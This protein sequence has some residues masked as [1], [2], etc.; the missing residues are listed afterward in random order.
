MK[1]FTIRQ[2]L[3]GM[4][5]VLAVIITALSLFFLNRFAAV[6][7]TYNNIPQIHVPQQQVV[8]ELENALITEQ[9]YIKQIH[10]VP[11]DIKSFESLSALSDESHKAFQILRNALLKGSTDLGKDMPSLKGVQVAPAEKGS[12]LEKAILGSEKSYQAYRKICDDIISKKR[13]QLELVNIIGW[14]DSETEN[15]GMVSSLAQLRQDMLKNTKDYT[16]RFLIEE[17]ANLEKAIINNPDEKAIDRFRELLASSMDMFNT[18]MTTQSE[19]FLEGQT[20]NKLQVYSDQFEK[21]QEKLLTLKS[22]NEELD[23]LV[24]KEFASKND[25]FGK[26]V[27]GIK[28]KVDHEIH[29]ATEAA[30]SMRASTKILISIIVLL[31]VGTAMVLGWYISFGINRTLDKVAHALG[32]SSEQVASAAGQ[33]SSSSQSM[34]DGSSEQ[35]ASIEETSS[36]LEEMSSMTKQNA[37]HAKQADLLMKEASEVVQ[38]ANSSMND[39]IRSMEEISKASDET[40][41]IIKTIDEIAFQTNLLALNAAVEA[42]RAGEAGAGFAVVADEVRNLAMR[43]A[44]AA[45]NT[46]TLIE[47]TVKKIKDGSVLVVKT[48][49]SFAH[50]SE[51]A[52]KVGELVSEIAAASREQAQGVEQVN[53]AVVEMDKIVQQNAANSEETASASEELSAQAEQMRIMVKEMLALI[54]GNPENGKKNGGENIVHHGPQIEKKKSYKI[55]S[56]QK[57]LSHSDSGGNGKKRGAHD[58]AEYPNEIRSEQIIPLDD[59]ELMNF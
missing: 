10:D 46:S 4:T 31:V 21:L 56:N 2:R 57:I 48:N 22:I 18:M 19:D 26:S 16:L 33:V 37:D 1:N 24:K 50:V 13:E 32:E 8:A 17:I 30:V 42:A 54:G 40:F 5:V 15:K 51:S 43:A 47:G 29:A 12:E 11:R 25:A 36:S 28:E 45:K 53:K 44:E 39:L 59:K 3:L 58:M 35:A 23:L 55:A 14:Y 38:E 20:T 41:K 34:A 49:E 52:T 7:D 6:S 27:A 9:V